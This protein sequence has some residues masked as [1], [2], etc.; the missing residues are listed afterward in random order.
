MPARSTPRRPKITSN[1]RGLSRGRCVC[2]GKRKQ[3]VIGELKTIEGK[4]GKM[5]HK[6]TD[7]ELGVNIANARTLIRN[8]NNLSV[9]CDSVEAMFSDRSLAKLGI[10]PCPEGATGDVR[11]AWLNKAVAAVTKADNDHVIGF[12]GYQEDMNRIRELF[13][14]VANAAK[15]DEATNPIGAWDAYWETYYNW[16]TEAWAPKQAL[17]TATA[18]QISRAYTQLGIHYG[19]Y[20]DPDTEATI[21]RLAQESLERV[22]SMDPGLSPADVVKRDY[23][24]SPTVNIAGK[25][26]TMGLL[27]IG[28]DS[29]VWCYSMQRHSTGIYAARVACTYNRDGVAVQDAEIDEYLSRLHGMSVLDDLRLAG[30]VPDGIFIDTAMSRGFVFQGEQSRGNWWARTL[31]WDGSYGSYK[32]AGEN[33]RSEPG[34][35]FVD[36]SLTL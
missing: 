27:G 36:L 18:H 24:A 11:N 21:S 33:L 32:A 20:G 29:P 3:D 14:D 15:E 10:E 16:E 6:L 25:D 28:F 7:I 5:D 17:R 23:D 30:L 9:Y 8:V 19:I 13:T 2:T 26:R 4:L 22:N 1:T 31:N 34:K 12:K 35:Y